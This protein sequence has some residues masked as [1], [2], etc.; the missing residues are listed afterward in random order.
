MKKDLFRALTIAVLAAALPLLSSGC[1]QKKVKTADE[2]LATTSV[3][4]V[5]APD[6][7]SP[8]AGRI[9]EGDIAAQALQEG[10]EESLMA[11]AAAQA[12]EQTAVLEGR[13]NGPMLPIYFDFDKSSIREDQQDRLVGNGSF[14]K[15]NIG[16]RVRIE[17]NCDERGTN[18][19]NMALG[20]RRAISAKNYLI[21][22]GIAENQLETISYGEERPLNYGHDEL[23]WSQNRRGDF[24]IIN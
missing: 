21:N 9:A 13:T 10:E 8:E 18:E 1:G 24:V 22:L 23:S 11:Q 5:Q 4:E 19:Y 2:S 6:V 16:L 3:S 14:M 17:G 7:T 12:A 20:E 15:T